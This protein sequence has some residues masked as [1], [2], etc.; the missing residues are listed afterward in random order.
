MNHFKACGVDVNEWLKS[1]QATTSSRD[2]LLEQIQAN[3]QDKK[4]AQLK[5][6]EL[7]A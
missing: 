2:Q 1:L 7:T 6:S 3:K 5:S 4:I